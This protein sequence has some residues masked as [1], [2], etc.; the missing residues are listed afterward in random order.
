MTI[1]ILLNV[2]LLN[3]YSLR[4]SVGDMILASG[5]YSLELEYELNVN[6]VC[7][8]QTH[9]SFTL[10]PTLLFVRWGCFN[11]LEHKSYQEHIL[12]ILDHS[13]FAILC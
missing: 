8:L 9:C 13:L 4:N 2:H 10:L 11:S 1:I 6:W 5:L 3:F 7:M 12:F